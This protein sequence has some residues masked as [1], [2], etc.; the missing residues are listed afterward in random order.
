MATNRAQQLLPMSP[1]VFDMTETVTLVQQAL[2]AE[3]GNEVAFTYRG[4]SQATVKLDWLVE[5]NSGGDV[6]TV[7]VSVTWAVATLPQVSVAV[8]VKTRL[9]AQLV[10]PSTCVTVMVGVLQLSVADTCAFTLVSV[11]KFVGLQPRLA[12]AGTLVITGGVGSTTVTVWLHEL[13]FPHKSVTRQVRVMICGQ[14]PLVTS[15][16]VKL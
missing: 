11:G 6:L 7:Q 14:I 3:G 15:L 12:P 9:L 1:K 16:K 8:M 5:L 4:S 2:T 10:F 13:V